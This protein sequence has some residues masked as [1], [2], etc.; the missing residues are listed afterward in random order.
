MGDCVEIFVN[1]EAGGRT[2]KARKQIAKVCKAHGL[3]PLFHKSEYK[4]H[5]TELC[6]AAVQRGV[7]R[8][9]VMGGDG[10]LREAAQALAHT[11]TA[12]AIL[13]CGTGN[14]WVRTL[15]IPR[16]IK[17][18]ME[19]ALAGVP[20]RMD[21]ICMDEDYAVCN[22]I[23]AGL[24]CI[25]CQ[26]AERSRLRGKFSYLSGLISAL[27]HLQP[28]QY[29]CTIDG[30]ETIEGQSIMVGIGNGKFIGGGI[31]V[32]APAE[33]DDG[34]LNLMLA[35]NLTRR[36]LIPVM[37]ILMR[38]KHENHP[39]VRFF[40]VKSAVFQ[41]EESIPC[42]ADGEMMHRQSFTAQIMERAI[43]V[44]L[45]KKQEKGPGQ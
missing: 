37:G 26:Y 9:F 43:D 28:M 14:D 19:I 24:G 18:A 4:G 1:D 29:R 13:P 15:G 27:K 2:G 33:T 25:T 21:L 30:R 16:K 44:I 3:I 10:T 45:P 35:N 22:Y 23:D 6:R 42:S 39:Y 17:P 38:G 41:F 7:D 12:L 20:Q 36:Q 40:K 8:V 5:I 34:Y 31:P 32:F 11:Q